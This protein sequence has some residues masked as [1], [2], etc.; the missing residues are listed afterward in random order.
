[1]SETVR[2]LTS[3]LECGRRSGDDW[4]HDWLHDWLLRLL[5]LDRDD[6]TDM[7]A[8]DLGGLGLY[9]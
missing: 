9:H 5:R 1:M 7:A 3:R 4:L 2:E 6:V 8:G